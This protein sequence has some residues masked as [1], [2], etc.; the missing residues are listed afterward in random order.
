MEYF[1]IF[2][3]IDLHSYQGAVGGSLLQTRATFEVDTEVDVYLF[4]VFRTRRETEIFSEVSFRNISSSYRAITS[5][6]I[7]SI[8]SSPRRGS[9]DDGDSYNVEE[10]NN[11][12]DNEEDNE[13]EDTEEYNMDKEKS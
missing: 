8:G 9:P 2:I 3:N 5:L 11:E 13:E 6:K 10:E 1:N 12:E 4:E 7:P